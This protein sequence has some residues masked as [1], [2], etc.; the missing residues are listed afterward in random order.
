MLRLVR[1]GFLE[2]QADKLRL[3]GRGR[4]RGSA[5]GKRKRMC[6]G[7]EVRENKLPLRNQMMFVKLEF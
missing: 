1:K 5:P 4:G 3:R 7:P 6:K 2:T